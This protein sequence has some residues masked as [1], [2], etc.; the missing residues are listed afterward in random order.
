MAV[1]F[2]PSQDYILV[3]PLEREHS[4]AL[5]VVTHER[6][7]RG[8]VVAVGPGKKDKK[9]RICRLDTRVGDIVHFGDGGKTLDTMFPT[10]IENNVL[11]RVIQ[12][13][14]VCYIEV[15]EE[16]TLGAP[17]LPESFSPH[18]GRHVVHPGDSKQLESPALSQVA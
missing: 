11:Y 16:S 2:R 10:Y 4:C 18:P 9:G 17:D 14:D 15:T 12:E 7:A 8:R 5:A 6:H 1:K 13:Q 3:E